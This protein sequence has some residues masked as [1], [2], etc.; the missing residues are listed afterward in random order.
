[1]QL[2]NAVAAGV[3]PQ[4]ASPG[5]LINSRAGQL[6]DMIVSELQGR[7]YEQT[8]RGNKFV[9]GLAALTAITNATFTVATL[10]ATCTPIL[11]VW[12]PGTSTVNLVIAQA[13]L[14]AAITAL[15]AT[16]GGPYVWCGSTGNN[17]LTLGSAPFSRKTLAAAGSQAKNMSGVALTGLTN[18]LVA[19][20]GSALGGGSSS[21]A[22]FVGTAAGMQTT[23][24]GF[25]ENFDGSLIVPPGGVLALLATTTPVAHSAVGSIVHDEVPT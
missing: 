4:S 19:M 9:S 18:N 1:M 8:Y 23:L 14:A 22:S 2:Q 13:T 6:G 10:G 11:G 12:N 15:T 20:F 7:L 16:G 24:Q 17:A 5:A 3:G 21:N 25:V